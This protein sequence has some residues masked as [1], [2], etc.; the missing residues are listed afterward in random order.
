MLIYLACPYTHADHRIERVRAEIATGVAMRVMGLGQAV[1]SPLSH[2]L[3]VCERGA[4]GNWEAWRVVNRRVIA[5]CDELHV[6]QLPGWDK[7][8][9][10]A[11]EQE[12]A[13]RLEKRRVYL[14][15]PTWALDML[16]AAEK[17]RITNPKSETLNPK[18]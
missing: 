10:V 11:D 8:E 17:M 12:E 15:A 6:L 16:A 14:E 4:A 18:S 2:S 3:E 13:I 7:S 1:F 9:G 5:V